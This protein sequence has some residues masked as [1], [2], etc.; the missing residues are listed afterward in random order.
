MS[1]RGTQTVR[2]ETAEADTFLRF[3][4][5]YFEKNRVRAIEVKRQ[6]KE[7]KPEAFAAKVRHLQEKVLP[8]YEIESCCL[9]IDDM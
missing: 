1:K 5:R 6:R 4:F 9:C 3:C 8:G 7:F 2:Y